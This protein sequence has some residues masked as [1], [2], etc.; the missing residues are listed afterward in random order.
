MQIENWKLQSE[1]LKTY[2]K[3]RDFQSTIS[4][5]FAV[6]GGDDGR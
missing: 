5:V 1:V 6:T 3:A 4:N 2:S